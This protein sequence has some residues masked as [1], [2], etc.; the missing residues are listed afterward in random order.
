M[1]TAAAAALVFFSM[2]SGGQA[3][4]SMY[5]FNFTLGRDASTA[6]VTDGAPCTIMLNISR[7]PIYGTNITSKPRGGTATVNGRTTVV[8]QPK[9]GFKGE[10]N[11]AIQYVGKR[12][13]ITPMASTSNVSV[14]V[15]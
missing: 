13:G 11:F 5:R 10:D 8:Y 1:R 9:S 12:D 15:N 14:T 6:G 2:A 3:A 4:C 7:H